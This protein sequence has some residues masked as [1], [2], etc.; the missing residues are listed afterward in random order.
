MLL[1]QT[2]HPQFAPSP[3][4][5]FL[6]LFPATRPFSTL[7]FK[8]SRSG[9]SFVL[10]LILGRRQ[11]GFH[12]CRVSCS[13]LL[14][15][16]VFV[17]VHYQVWYRLLGWRICFFVFL[18]LINQEWLFKFCQQIFFLIYWGDHNFLFFLVC[19]YVMTLI[20]KF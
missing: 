13:Y 12:S 3:T 15:V 1:L 20:F 6:A 18:F 5:P 14:V 19:C 7:L 11:S 9:L 4:L 16:G 10:F 8:N 2:P 17:A